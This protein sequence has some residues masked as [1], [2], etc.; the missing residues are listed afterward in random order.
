MLPHK[1]RY[2]GGADIRVNKHGGEQVDALTPESLVDLSERRLPKD[3]VTGEQ[4]DVWEAKHYM[5]YALPPQDFETQEKIAE[6]ERLRKR[7]AVESAQA[8]VK[9]KREHERALAR[10]RSKRYYKNKKKRK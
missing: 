9:A 2:G 1:R 10:D 3:P 6:Q 5:G 7:L 8:A 4:W